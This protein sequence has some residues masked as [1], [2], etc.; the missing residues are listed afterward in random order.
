MF[1]LEFSPDTIG[2]KTIVTTSMG[3]HNG[4]SHDGTK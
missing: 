4:W 1:T 3:L 2:Q